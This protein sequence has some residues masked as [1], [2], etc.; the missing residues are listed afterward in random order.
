MK[1]RGSILLSPP[2]G[3]FNLLVLEALYFSVDILL[4]AEPLVLGY[5]IFKCQRMVLVY[6]LPYLQ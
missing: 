4:T 1:S 5:L 3:P 2:P 6:L